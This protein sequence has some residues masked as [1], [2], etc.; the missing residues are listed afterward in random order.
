LSFP[1]GERWLGLRSVAA[2]PYQC[3]TLDAI[4]LVEYLPQ[5]DDQITTW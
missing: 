5:H 1:G 2:T 3:V 4:V